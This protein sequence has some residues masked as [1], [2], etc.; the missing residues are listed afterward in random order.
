MR[1]AFVVGAE[2][3]PESYWRVLLPSRALR[4]PALGTM[5][6]YRGERPA[7]AWIHEPLSEAAL[8]IA[9]EV[10]ARGGR[11]VADWTEDAWTR[12]ECGEGVTMYSAAM[13]QIGEQVNAL[14]DVIVV[15]NPALADF[16]RGERVEVIEPRLAALP[17]L[18]EKRPGVIGWWADG[19]QRGGLELAGPAITKAVEAVDGRFWHIQFRH[20]NALKGLPVSRQHIVAGDA[21]IDHLTRHAGMAELAVDCWPA[22]SYRDTTSDIG[23]LRMAALGVPS[24]TT[25]A[26]APPGTVSA[27]HADW[28][29]II[30]HLHESPEARRALSVA[31]RRWAA[32]R[33]GF[34][35]YQALLDSLEAR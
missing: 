27:P 19:R 7:I 3:V 13:L 23:L 24:L 14:A 4:V 28:P 9:Q 35:P 11:V 31:G 17:E 29:D 22:V 16:M 20:M 8:T 2:G 25:R 34:E 18:G 5:E 6:A 1:L 21:E 30:H 12:D 15:A 10:K 32:T 33:L 26:K